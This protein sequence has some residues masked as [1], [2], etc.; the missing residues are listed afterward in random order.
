MR[1]NGAPGGLG[2]VVDGFHI[3]RLC[4][5]A[6]HVEDKDAAAV[7]TSEPEL[8]PVIGEPAVVRFIAS[9][10]GIA[11]D[12]FAVVRRVRLYINGDKFVEAIAKAFHA[13]RPNIDK[14]LLPIDAGKV[15]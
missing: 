9:L 6:V 5:V 15:R 14:F 4:R 8:T 1:S 11:A 12:D 3:L 13:K 7:E 2:K 10:D